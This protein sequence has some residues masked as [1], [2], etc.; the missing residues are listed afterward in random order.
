MEGVLEKLKSKKLTYN[1]ASKDI[2]RLNQK[3][4]KQKRDSTLDSAI[5]LQKGAYFGG[6]TG[7]STRELDRSMSKEILI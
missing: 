5:G 3:R 4:W 2:I 6:K 1:L 7:L